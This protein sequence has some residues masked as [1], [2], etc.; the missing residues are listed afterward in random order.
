[1]DVD[2][3]HGGPKEAGIKERAECIWLVDW[4]DDLITRALPQSEVV[5]HDQSLWQAGIQAAGQ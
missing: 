3:V 1:L 5:G 2:R 4:R